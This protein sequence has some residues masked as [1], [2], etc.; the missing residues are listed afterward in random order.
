MC[1]EGNG[2]KHARK[3]TQVVTFLVLVLLS[4]SSC[5]TTHPTS[6]RTE[7]RDSSYTREVVDTTIVIPPITIEEKAP[8][9]KDTV[10]VFKDKKATTTIKIQKDT[11]Y[12]KTDISGYELQ[13]AGLIREKYILNTKITELTESVKP[14]ECITWKDKALRILFMLILFSILMLIT[15]KIVTQKQD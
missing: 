9:T 4:F 8:I 6:T 1:K 5:K 14:C 11:V 3:V 10:Y 13:I 7:T 12:V 15:A 2:A